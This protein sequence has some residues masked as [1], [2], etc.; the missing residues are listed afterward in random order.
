[1][2]AITL[3]NKTLAVKELRGSFVYYVNEKNQVKCVE[4]SKVEVI[5]VEESEIFKPKYS[6]SK[7]KKL[8][9]ANFMSE[10]EFSKSKYYHMDKND[11]E[12]MRAADSRNSISF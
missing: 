8:N 3:E 5:E 4:L 1:M 2:K 12:D 7:T 9:P 6:N 11:Y 10:A